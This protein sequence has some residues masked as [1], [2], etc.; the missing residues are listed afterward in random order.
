MQLPKNRANAVVNSRDDQTPSEVSQECTKR[1]EPLRFVEQPHGTP[2]Q[3]FI[4]PSDKKTL[5][6]N[7]D[8]VR[9]AQLIPYRVDRICYDPFAANSTR[10]RPTPM[11]VAK[12]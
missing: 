4:N 10:S 5:L 11:V 7:N 1:F 12:L 6:A 3:T 8:L 9:P 2:P